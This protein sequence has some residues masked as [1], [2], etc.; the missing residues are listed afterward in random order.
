MTVGSNTSGGKVLLTGGSGFIAS[1][2]LDCLLAEGF[3][4]VATARS[5][6]KGHQIIGGVEAQYAKNV[7]YA[8]VEDIAQPGAFDNVLQSTPFDFI[9]HAAS[10][11]HL[12]VVDPVK[13]FLDPAIKGTTGLLQS[14]AS[15]APTVRR[16]VITSSSAAMLNPGHHA[17]VYDE[18]FW[19]PASWEMAMDPAHTYRCSKVFAERAAWEFIAKEKPRFD[20]AV[21]NSTYNFGPVQR[22]LPSLDAMN[23]SNHRIRDMVLGRMKDKIEPTAPVYTWV[24][25]RDV[26]EAH[27]RAMTLPEAGGN[28][29][30]IV[31]GHFSNKRIADIIRKNFPQL[32]DKLPPVDVADDLPD[33]VYRFNNT[34]SR[35]VLRLEYT[36]LEKSVIDTVRSILEHMDHDI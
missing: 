32:N 25:V 24:D 34:K 18:T 21:I 26:G 35:Q 5:K 14:I 13:D 33:D 19:A 16:V 36:G 23:T 3:E 2:I 9:I 29:F 15:H 6:Q 11:Y 8:V 12:N 10:P 1:H 27:V 20:L 4:V 31:G 30:Y 17:A 22:R 7:E 28:R